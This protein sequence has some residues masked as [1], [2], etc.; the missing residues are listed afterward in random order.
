MEFGSKYVYMKTADEDEEIEIDDGAM[1]KL[2]L[3]IKSKSED[4]SCSVLFLLGCMYLEK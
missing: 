3:D 2:T 1:A 4:V